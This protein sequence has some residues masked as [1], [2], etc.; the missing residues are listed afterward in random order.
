M[1][2]NE[3]KIAQA[4]QSMMIKSF[5]HINND[6][7]SGYQVESYGRRF[8]ILR[9]I[10]KRFERFFNCHF[11]RKTSIQEVMA[12]DIF[13]A[14]I[15]SK[16]FYGVEKCFPHYTGIGKGFENSSKFFFFAL[17]YVSTLEEELELYTAIAA[18]VHFQSQ[19]SD[20]EFFNKY[21]DKVAFEVQGELYIVMGKERVK[22]GKVNTLSS[23]LFNDDVE[24]L[25]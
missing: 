7:E 2:A 12:S 16:Y 20:V 17:N 19:F 8:L 9:E 4:R 11:G 13:N 21:K 10:Y 5:F 18:H 1:L 24:V 3:M 15:T 22:I 23:S 6:G 14:F 25:R